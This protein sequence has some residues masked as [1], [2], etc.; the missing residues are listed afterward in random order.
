MQTGKLLIS[1]RELQKKPSAG[2]PITKIRR[3]PRVNGFMNI[4]TKYV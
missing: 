3:K 2:V 4:I 1:N